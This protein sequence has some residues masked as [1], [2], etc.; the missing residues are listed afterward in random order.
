MLKD[1]SIWKQERIPLG[2][3]QSLKWEGLIIW[4]EKDWA[5]HWAQEMSIILALELT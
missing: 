2:Q 1:C 4:M 3:R 5:I